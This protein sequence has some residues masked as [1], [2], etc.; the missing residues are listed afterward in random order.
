[1]SIEVVIARFKERLGWTRFL[2][3]DAKI[4]VYNMGPDEVEGAIR[5][6]DIK[7]ASDPFVHLHHIIARYDSLADWTFFIQGDPFDHEPAIVPTIN[8]WPASLSSVNSFSPEDGLHCFCPLGSMEVERNC[9]TGK[10]K[11]IHEMVGEVWREL[12]SCAPPEQMRFGPGFH[13]AASLRLLHT[14]RRLFYWRLYELIHAREMGPW[15]CER[16]LGV[17]WSSAHA[18]YVRA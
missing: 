3:T 10:T 1:M 5:L 6:P 13:F 12:Y 7:T 2:R 4:T 17:L 9:W 14:R 11:P 16:I 18:Q 15:E 8:W